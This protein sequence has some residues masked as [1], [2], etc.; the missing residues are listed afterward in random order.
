MS[1]PLEM[2]GDREPHRIHLRAY[3]AENKD[4]KDEDEDTKEKGKHPKN[5]K[6]DAHKDRPKER[7]LVFDTETTTGVSQR[8]RFGAYQIYDGDQLFEDG[9]FYDEDA[10]EA[11]ELVLL[12]HYADHYSYICIPVAEF[13]KEKF[14][15]ETALLEGSI[16]GFNLPFDISRIAVRHGTAKS[17]EWDRGFHNGFSFRLIDDDKYPHVRV[18][19]IS[20]S[21]AFIKF[22]KT[23]NDNAGRVP[24]GEEPP[25]YKCPSFFVDVKT[26]AAT[27]IR[28][29]FSLERLSK[30]LGIDTPKQSSSEHGQRLTPEYIEYAMGDVQATWECYR[31]LIKKL[32]E[33]GL[34]SA[35]PHKLYSEAS[36][37]KAYLKQMG[38]K[39][40][41]EV[42]PDFDE[43][44]I[45]PI[46]STYYGGRA[47]VRIRRQATEVAYC[48]FLSMYPTVC[49][50]MK[51]W[52]FVTAKGVEMEDTTEDARN[53]FNGLNIEDLSKPE[54]WPKLTMLV[55]IKPDGDVLPV[56]TIYR[57]TVAK[58]NQTPNIGLNHLTSP[59]PLWFTL[60][61]CI[62]SKLLTGK[63]PEIVEALR[64]IPKERQD[65]LQPVALAGD[66]DYSVDPTKDDFFKTVIKLRRSVKGEG[67][68]ATGTSEE[69]RLDALQQALKIL[70]NSTSYGIFIELIVQVTTDKNLRAYGF[71][72]RRAVIKSNVK[73]K[74]G[75]YFHP[76]LA[77]LITG[78]ARLMLALAERKAAD[79]ELDWCFCDTDGITFAKPGD[80]ER[81]EFAKR[82]HDVC[83]WFGGL[84]PYGDESSILELEDENFPE[85][86][87]GSLADAPPLYCYAVS[88]KR[89]AL[90]NSTDDDIVIRKA[91][92]HG[93]GHLQS[94]YVDPDDA[95]ETSKILRWHKD[96]W[97]VICLAADRGDDHPQF[98]DERFHALAVSRYA[99]TSSELQKWFKHYNEG[100]DYQDQ[101]RPFG[102]LSIYSSTDLSEVAFTDPDAEAWVEAHGNDP[103]PVSPYSSDPNDTELEIFDRETGAAFERRWLESYANKL[104]LYHLHS[105]AKFL[106][107]NWDSR[108]QTK[109]RRIE[110]IGVQ[111]CGKEADNWEEHMIV[112]S[113]V[114]RTIPSIG[115]LFQIDQLK[116]FIGAVKPI[117]SVGRLANVAELRP[118]T[119]INASKPRTMFPDT[120]IS[121]LVISGFL[122]LEAKQIEERLDEQARALMKHFVQHYSWSSLGRRLDIDPSNAKKIADGNRPLPSELR[123]TIIRSLG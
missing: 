41:Q 23:K 104:S 67:K 20:P 63:T 16:V 94:P 84:N 80:M 32:D 54:F 5:A 58:G 55:R 56:R 91:S 6:K 2:F 17:D 99:V 74:P 121:K 22:A 64:F 38:I 106:N 114:A 4:T 31:A 13:I 79:A 88:A 120:V 53:L 82:I 51:L 29:G 116:Q 3:M 27:L 87:K 103:K 45:G 107:G 113:P 33:H 30:H 83:D 78:A 93:L 62:A 110:V 28:P 57:S 105:E 76:L 35:P 68:Q 90:F 73:E 112:G 47:E 100:R 10:L 49:S 37:G 19:R 39:P 75:T 34:D 1:N 109:R 108:G 71:D 9:F 65:G 59:E 40:W 72:G 46:M 48:D 115:S 81:A 11:D 122:L 14:F 18:K 102:F 111:F 36:L 26:L 92:A 101:V 85:D 96:L 70:A 95:T 117:V 8:L 123:A 21:A 69:A 52:D 118:E 7:T 98:D 24:K 66:S 97:R 42:Q 77:T 43:G 61:D 15:A 25:T 44:L 119:V 50:L 60:A 86:K 12:K 89:Y